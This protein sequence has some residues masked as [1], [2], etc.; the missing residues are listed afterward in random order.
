MTQTVTLSP[1]AQTNETGDVALRYF[2]SGNI[3][4]QETPTG[5]EYVAQTFANI[6]LAWVDPADVANILTR[7]GGCCGGAKR[8]LFHC[9]SADDV[10]RWMNRGGQ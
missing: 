7:R 8:Q 2:Q 9:A 3:L 5:K 4:I 10:R 6:C 1:E